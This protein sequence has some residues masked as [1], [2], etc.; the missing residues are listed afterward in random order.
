MESAGSR[1]GTRLKRG[2]TP[3][4]AEEPQATKRHHLAKGKAP[5]SSVKGE[6]EYSPSPHARQQ[7]EAAHKR[8]SEDRELA[9]AKTAD[10]KAWSDL[11]GKIVRRKEYT[12]ADSQVKERL[13]ADAR[14]DLE[15]KR[16]Q[17]GKSAEWLEAQARIRMDRDQ[18]EAWER[19]NHQRAA[20][21]ALIRE[22]QGRGKRIK[23]TLLRLWYSYKLTSLKSEDQAVKSITTACSSVFKK[24]VD[25]VIA[26]IEKRIYR[27]GR[28]ELKAACDTNIDAAMTT[29]NTQIM[30]PENVSDAATSFHGVD[31]TKGEMV[32]AILS[33]VSAEVFQSSDED[34]DHYD[35]DSD[36]SFVVDDH[37]VE[38]S[39]EDSKEQGIS[40]G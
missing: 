1:Y 31:E 33:Q 39:D 16:W 29:F 23:V 10:R 12:K 3:S 38:E 35:D 26:R 13:L 6:T 5:M 25:P 21:L 11:K 27:S 14:D 20:A 24:H 32:R 34:E 18:Q 19:D 17:L 28:R 30:D 9:R 36:D 2:R 8:S 15:Q 37:M 7:R 4:K 40:E 22:Q